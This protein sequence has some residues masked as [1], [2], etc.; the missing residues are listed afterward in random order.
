MSYEILLNE[1]REAGRLFETG[2]IAYS[3]LKKL[4]LAYNANVEIDSFLKQAKTLFPHLNCGLAAVYLQHKLGGVVVTGS[5]EGQKHTFLMLDNLV[6]D[7][8]ADQ[9]G[10]PALYVGS[11]VSPWSLD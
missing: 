1:V 11:L 10:G 4:Y 9:F 2:A 7:I 5:Y 8:T 3:L 6:L